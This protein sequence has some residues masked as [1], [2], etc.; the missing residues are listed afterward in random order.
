MNGLETFRKLLGVSADQKP[1]IRHKPRVHPKVSSVSTASG[2]L[3]KRHSVVDHVL[4]EFQKLFGRYSQT[5]P[6]NRTILQ[7]C[8]SLQNAC[9]H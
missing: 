8:T 2:I 6:L 7:V 4:T 9:N 1:K 5:A 3:A